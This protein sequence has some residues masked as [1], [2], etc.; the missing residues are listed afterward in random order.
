VLD[1]LA[2]L[3]VPVHIVRGNTDYDLPALLP[4]Q[5][6]E[7]GGKRFA[8]VHGDNAWRFEETISGQQFDYVITG[9]THV[10]RDERHGRTRVIN[11]G[12]VHRA[13]EPSVAILETESDRLAFLRLREV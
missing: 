6:V 1:A 2:E 8:L 5:R 12:A 10:A 9:H 11:P 4:F 7:L 13:A 3:G